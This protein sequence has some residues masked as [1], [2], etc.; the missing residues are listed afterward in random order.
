M[1]RGVLVLAA[2]A[3]VL[4]T[5]VPTASSARPGWKWK[6]TF[7]PGTFAEGR[8]CG[9]TPHGRWNFTVRAKLAGQVLIQKWREDVR[10]DGRWRPVVYTFVGGSY[11]ESRERQT[12]GFRAKY[13]RSLQGTSRV[14]LAQ[15]NKVIE[16]DNK[17]KGIK[18]QPFNPV[19]EAC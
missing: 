19:R 3:V 13:L 15:G 8:H 7:L 16:H 4:T 10:P 17:G 6:Q 18:R 5:A 2:L 12:P 9:K 1:R 11:I 14:R